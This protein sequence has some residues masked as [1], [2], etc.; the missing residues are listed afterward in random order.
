MKFFEKMKTKSSIVAIVVCL[1]IFSVSAAVLNATIFSDPQII[2]DNG[3]YEGTGKFDKEM[4]PCTNMLIIVKVLNG[5]NLC[6]NDWYKEVREC[7]KL[8]K[9]QVVENKKSKDPYVQEMMR[10]QLQIIDDLHAISSYGLGKKVSEEDIHKLQKSYDA[11][12]KYY[13]DNYG[14]V[15]I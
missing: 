11:Y 9:K 1:S 4:T 3:Y 5:S 13:Y 14:K 15:A 8:L 7:Q 6:S 10:L 12:S 2:E